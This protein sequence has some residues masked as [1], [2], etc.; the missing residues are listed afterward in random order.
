MDRDLPVDTPISFI[1]RIVR[2]ER[3][4]MTGIVEHV[5]SG[6]KRRFAGVSEMGRIIEQIVAGEPR[7]SRREEGRS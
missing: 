3:G 1:V 7:E 4:P 5:G 2:R 6:A